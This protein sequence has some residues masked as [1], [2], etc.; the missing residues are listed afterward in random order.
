[1]AHVGG[2]SL[3]Y[4]LNNV[5]FRFGVQPDPAGFDYRPRVLTFRR[6]IMPEVF[7]D[8]GYGCGHLESSAARLKV[9]FGGRTSASTGGSKISE[10]RSAFSASRRMKQNNAVRPHI[11]NATLKE[12]MPVVIAVISR[13]DLC[14]SSTSCS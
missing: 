9:G 8:S 3:V 10:T 4:C 5:I 12:G 13:S 14:G 2:N 7:Q 6:P 1:M 11:S